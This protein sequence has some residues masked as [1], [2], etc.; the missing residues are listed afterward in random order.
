MRADID[1]YRRLARRIKAAELSFRSPKRKGAENMILSGKVT[2]IH[3]ASQ[4]TDNCPR[5]TLRMAQPDENGMDRDIGTMQIRSDGS[6]E[7]GE[8]VFFVLTNGYGSAT[9][10]DDRLRH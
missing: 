9:E 2:S 8:P 4:F 6:L 1:R 3:D 10:I 5:V 7:L